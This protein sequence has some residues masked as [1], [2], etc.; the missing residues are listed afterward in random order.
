MQITRHH[1]RVMIQ[2]DVSKPFE[3]LRYRRLI[4][5]RSYLQSWCD[6][7]CAPVSDKRTTISAI[8][9]TIHAAALARKRDAVTVITLSK[10]M[11]LRSTGH[12]TA[13]VIERYAVWKPLRHRRH[14]TVPV[15]NGQA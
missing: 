12:S 8:A 5:Y 4:L 1:L 15:S 3:N 10:K 13:Q 9:S 11:G 14:S 2:D 7:G 6:I